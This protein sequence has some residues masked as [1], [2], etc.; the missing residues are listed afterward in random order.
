VLQQYSGVHALPTKA[1]A[2]LSL[3]R[4]DERQPHSWHILR[5]KSFRLYFYGSVA[6][7]FGTWMQ[8]T[9]QVLLAYRLAHS[10]LAV[11][12]V[13]CAQFSSPLVLGPWAAVMSDRFGGR[14]TLLCTQLV[15]AL[16]SAL[17]AV[18]EFR[19]ALTEWWL[20]GGA[21]VS[22]L[23]FTF[24]LPARNVT[25]RGLVPPKD[26]RP[27]YVMDAV[28]YN[29][30]RAVAP[31]LTVV[32]VTTFGY[33]WAFAANALTFM[34]FTLALVLARHGAAEPERRSR[35]RDGFLIARRDRT[36]MFLLL[37]VAAVTVADDPVL[38]LGPTLAHH[39]HASTNWSG[40]FIAALGSGSVIGSLRRPKHLPTLQLAAAAL[41]LLG[42]CM[43]LFVVTPC[44]WVSFAAAVG[45]GVSCLLANSMTR[46][47]LS[48]AAGPD[49]VAS[50]MAVWA[51]AWAGSKPL[52]SLADGALAGWVGVP[53][54]GIVLA[55]PAF[56]PFAVLVV[57][58]YRR[59]RHTTLTTTALRAPEFLGTVA[60]DHS[61]P[62]D[63]QARQ[64]RK[65]SQSVT[66]GTCIEVA[67]D[68]GALLI[69][70]SKDPEGLTIK[71]TATEFKDFLAKAKDGVF[72]T[73]GSESTEVQPSLARSAEYSLRESIR[74][75]IYD[76][77]R[78][79]DELRR[80]LKILRFFRSTVLAILVL[81]LIGSS[82]VG[83]GVGAAVAMAGIRL[84]V[85]MGIGAA[86]TGT[87]ALTVALRVRR[88]LRIALSA[89]SGQ[90]PG[91]LRR[92]PSAG[93]A[94]QRE[95]GL[96]PEV[97]PDPLLVPRA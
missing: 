77:T 69:R 96:P 72:D 29:L 94:A 5:N 19:G 36:I 52:A 40:W 38:V 68:N 45:A 23:A 21:L 55:L 62:Q 37:M 87:F 18:G 78:S 95:S 66:T 31:P 34:V 76:A 8:N 86:G 90:S 11:G 88:Y 7:D 48:K 80:H 15:S 3:T 22:G 63:D 74:G 9:A 1:S 82:L 46:T 75:L 2:F 56:M 24:A 50:V 64:W 17:L 92:E 54:T 71:V 61:W 28:S 25:V 49:R 42:L 53:A 89:L 26:T 81:L 14:R 33:W 70:D 58:A 39:F 4:S 30:G 10:A 12:L 84:P 91:R 83:V 85:A 27:A 47:L 57:L 35:V 41:A 20:V 13:T 73:L 6:S 43:I 97:P 67:A 16:I 51:I 93:Q 60:H 59:R 32:L 79:N 65:S 44:I